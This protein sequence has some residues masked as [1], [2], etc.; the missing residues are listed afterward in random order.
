MTSLVLP[1]CLAA[2]SNE[3]LLPQS[4]LGEL[5]IFLNPIPIPNSN[6]LIPNRIVPPPT[7]RSQRRI[8]RIRLLKMQDELNIAPVHILPATAEVNNMEVAA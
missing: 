5:D 7:V 8:A 2:T 4:L 6:E 3:T 1:Y